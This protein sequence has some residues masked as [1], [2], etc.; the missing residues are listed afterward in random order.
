MAYVPNIVYDVTVAIDA[1]FLKN[2][3]NDSLPKAVFSYE[4]GSIDKPVIG[5]QHID[6]VYKVVI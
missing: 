1:N 2:S 5:N 4:L 6:L 3:T